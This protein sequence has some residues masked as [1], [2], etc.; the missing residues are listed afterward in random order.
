MFIS[1]MEGREHLPYQNHLDAGLF[2]VVMEA[3]ED[4]HG[5]DRC[6]S[7]V[8]VT[9]KGIVAIQRKLAS[10]RPLS[11]IRSQRQGGEVGR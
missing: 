11:L 1:D 7:K 8:L 5:R 2:K 10:S 9:G 4:S 3:F 6:Y